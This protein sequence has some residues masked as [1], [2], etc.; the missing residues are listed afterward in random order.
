MQLRGLHILLTYQCTF[1]C[2]HCFVF[3]SP[4]QNGV[5]TLRELRDVLRQA[6]ATGTITSIY[7]EGGEPF[8]YHPILVA[9]V[10]AAHGLGFTVGIVSNAY[11]ATS[12][13]D[14]RQWLLPLVGLVQDLSISSD[15]FHYDEKLS[16]QARAASAAAH[17]LGIST[18][19]ITIE[20]ADAEIGLGQL[21]E[22]ESGVMYRGR[23]ADKLAPLAPQ[24]PWS[25]FRE[26][27]YEDLRQPGRVHLDPFGNLHL[28]QGLTIGN[29]FEKD[30]A[31][32]CAGYDPDAHPVVGPLLAGGPAALALQYGITPRDTYADA[33]HLCFETR[34]ALRERFP[35]L[36]CP[37]QMYA[38]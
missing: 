25:D 24:H 27:P 31:A 4:N 13:E 26:C 9:A 37:D 21:P 29:L 8:L 22:G 2:D 33:C 12:V 18:G 7:F 23:A 34:R 30:L 1:A 15:L 38:G 5:L 17:E 16:R 6:Q 14:A 19:V 20:K 36:L 11:W 32:I 3:G 28:C 10:Q 35:T